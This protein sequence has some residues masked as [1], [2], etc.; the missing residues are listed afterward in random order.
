MFRTWL[1]FVISCV[2]PVVAGCAQGGAGAAGSAADVRNDAAVKQVLAGQREDANA[3]WWGFDPVES[4]AALQA[5]IDSHAKRVLV[6]YM[7]APW[8][9]RPITLRSNQ[10]IDFEPGVLILAKRGEFQ[11]GGDSLFTAVGVDNLT[12]RGYGATLRMW[13]KDYQNPP[14]KKAEWRMGIG[15][16]GSRNVLIEG[17]RVES[18]GGDGFYV[19]GGSGRLWSENITIR[20]C[21]AFDNHRQ[22]I[23]VISVVNLLVENSTFAGTGGTAPEAGI[24]IEPDTPQQRLVNIVIRNCV[25]EDNHGHEI[26]LYLR[27]MNHTTEPV[28]IRFEH[29]LSRQTDASIGGWSGMTVGEIQD[30][31][32]K[33]LIEFVDCVSENTGEEGTKVYNKSADGA[34]VRFVRCKWSN[35]W[36]SAHPEYAGPRVPVLIELRRPKSTRHLGGVEFRDCYVYDKVYRPALQVEENG[37]EFGVRDI[38]GLITVQNPAGVRVRLGHSP[39]NADVQVKPFPAPE[40]ATAK[41]P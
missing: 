22:G 24:D 23:S 38:H 32:P 15:I 12:M 40:A 29:C 4:T 13:K 41:A 18:S 31:G 8:I 30:D 26:A 25:F 3:A 39:I 5:A 19:D 28:S 14:Y 37:S 35:S 9:V 21:T 7:G 2:M 16:R 1:A 17:L 10:E 36:N 11:D 34:L 6:P 33:G 27:Q 20:D